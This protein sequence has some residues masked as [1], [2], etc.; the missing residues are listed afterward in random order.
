MFLIPEDIIV[1]E[2]VAVIGRLF[3]N[4]GRTNGAV[5]YKRRDAIE[6]RRG[7]GKRLQRGAEFGLPVDAVF[8]PQAAQQVVIFHGQRDALADIFAKPRVDGA[9]IA[10]PHH[11]IH[12]AAGEVL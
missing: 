3:C 12:T 4:L 11:Q 5:P 9:G 8:P 7:R 10:A 1:K 2:P 6:G